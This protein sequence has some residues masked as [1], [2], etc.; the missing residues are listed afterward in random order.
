M[1]ISCNKDNETRGSRQKGVVVFFLNEHQNVVFY[2]IKQT[3]VLEQI[4][5]ILQRR[6]FCGY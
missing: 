4:G 5:Q 2:I 6:Y 1:I 3:F